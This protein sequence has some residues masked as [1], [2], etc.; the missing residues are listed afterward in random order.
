MAAGGE[1][2]RHES[3]GTAF[4]H[5]GV[6]QLPRRFRFLLETAVEKARISRKHRL[7]GAGAGARVCSRKSRPNCEIEMAVRRRGSRVA[8]GLLAG[9]GIGLPNPAEKTSDFLRSKTPRRGGQSFGRV[10]GRPGCRSRRQP[11]CL[12]LPASEFGVRIF[13]TDSSRFEP[14]NRSADAVVGQASRLSGE[15]SIG[16]ESS[17]SLAVPP[18]RQDACPTTGFG[19]RGPSPSGQYL[20]SLRVLGVATALSTV[21]WPSRAPQRGRL[22]GSFRG[23]RRV[24]WLFPVAGQ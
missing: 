17:A 1:G 20:V 5:N 15:A 6:W 18:D 12:T 14:P 23:G 2:R 3:P 9:R 19:G 21:T 10:S 4:V 7:K 11:A 22:T 24:P 16:C 13:P 8:A